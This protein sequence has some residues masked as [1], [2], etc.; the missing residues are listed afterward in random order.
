MTRDEIKDL[1][2]TRLSMRVDG[3]LRQQAAVQDLIFDIPTIIATLSSVFTLQVGDIIATGTPEGVGL[4]FNPPRFLQHSSVME[5]KIDYI[6]IL[7]NRIEF[8]SMQEGSS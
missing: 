5:A 4:G 3:E 6:G 7:R 2:N 1:K 8:S